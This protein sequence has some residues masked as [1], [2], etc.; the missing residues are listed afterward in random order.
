MDKM[1]RND[2][3]GAIASGRKDFSGLDLSQVSPLEEV[4][5]RGFILDGVFA[6]NVEWEVD[7]T[8]ASMEKVSISESVLN[9]SNL[10]GA[11]LNGG[12]FVGTEFISA[13]LK[14]VQGQKV[15]FGFAVL[16]QAVLDNAVL[17]D[18]FF[19]ETGFV[20]ASLKGVDFSGSIFSRSDFNK[21]DVSAANFT[22]ATLNVPLGV[23]RIVSSDGAIGWNE[24][25]QE[26]FDKRQATA[27]RKKKQPSTPKPKPDPIVTPDGSV[28]I[29]SV[30][31][32][33][34]IRMK[35]G[36]EG[37][38]A[39]NKKNNRMMRNVI[40][41]GDYGSTYCDDIAAVWRDGWIPIS[42]QKKNPMAGWR[43]VLPKD[44]LSPS[45]RRLK[46][47]LLRKVINRM[48]ED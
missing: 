20:N 37:V 31:K 5:M 23:N 45:K 35:D 26:D 21:A 10:D 27:S 29:S 18:C 43:S 34:K 47:T 22:D 17:Q 19:R 1:T 8:G 38:M 42:G 40:V 32:G 28:D 13:S 12:S 30:S 39:D 41:N 15:N 4:D 7:L 16:T 46:T 6:V 25:L 14:D 36:F 24:A 2:F 44:A 3:M 33:E 48:N 9:F 11:I